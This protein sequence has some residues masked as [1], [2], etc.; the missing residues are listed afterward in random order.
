M[1]WQLIKLQRIFMSLHTQSSERTQYQRDLDQSRFEYEKP[2]AHEEELKKKLIRQ[3]ELNAQ[4]DL[5]N[6]R[7]ED[8]DLSASQNGIQESNVAE[9]EFEYH[10]Q[11]DNRGR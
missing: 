7:V 3:Y 2:F 11:N 1:R 4:L 9:R 6:G 10:T 8:V 5:E